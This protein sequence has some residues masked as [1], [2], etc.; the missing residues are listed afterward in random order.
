[1]ASASGS[2]E[3]RPLHPSGA[4]GPDPAPGRGGMRSSA[5]FDIV[6]DPLMSGVYLER[7]ANYGLTREELQSDKPKIGIAQTGSDLSPWVEAAPLRRR[8][9]PRRL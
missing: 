9:P 3:P 6:D 2:G 5:W 1:M 7:Y 4:S 8:G